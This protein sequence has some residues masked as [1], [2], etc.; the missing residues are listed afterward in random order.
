MSYKVTDFPAYRKLSNDKVY[1]KIVNDR[2]F[3]EIQLIGS[4]AN[5]FRMTATQYPEILKIQDMLK[6]ESGYR[7]S[8]E[9]EF[10]QLIDHF[11]LDSI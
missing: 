9:E 10:N 1:Y 5:L 6:C 11:G 4:K 3:E 7:I 2:Y 8:T